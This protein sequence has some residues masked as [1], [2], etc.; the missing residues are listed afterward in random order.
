MEA[1]CAR[2]QSEA[3]RLLND[4]FCYGWHEATKT[5]LPLSKGR[6]YYISKGLWMEV[7]RD[8]G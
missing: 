4:F 8:L 5:L 1:F 2:A 6:E 3:C 7:L